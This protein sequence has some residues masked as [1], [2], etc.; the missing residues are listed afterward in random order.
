MNGISIQ[1]SPSVLT[2]SRAGSDHAQAM[3]STAQVAI[4]YETLALLI[5]TLGAGPAFSESGTSTA[6]MPVQLREPTVP[7]EEAAQRIA[8]NLSAAQTLVGDLLGNVNPEDLQL[9]QL[10]EAAT[11][12]TPPRA[13]ALS[14]T[15]ESERPTVQAIPETQR[16]TP[17]PGFPLLASS[18]LAQLLMYMSYLLM[19]FGKQE[20]ENS[21]EM[22]TFRRKTQ[23]EANEQKIAAAE[24]AIY[25]AATGLA[26]TTALGGVALKKTY[27]GTDMQ[28][29]NV[30]KNQ[31]PGNESSVAVATAAKATK[32]GS[33]PTIEQRP[34]RDI[35]GVA[36]PASANG[37]QVAA[38]LQADV[39]AG[40]PAMRAVVTANPARPVADSANAA[41]NVVS[42]LAQRPLMQGALA[43]MLAGVT[44]TLGSTAWQPQKSAQEAAEALLTTEAQVEAEAAANANEQKRNTMEMAQAFF[45]MAQALLSQKSNTADHIT[46]HI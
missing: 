8:L 42:A 1:L 21:A 3:K 20:R 26:L 18:E 33:L 30:I 19:E 11:T 12:A 4:G 6:A 5:S 39:D 43:N 40:T 24:T 7:A 32:T 14:R 2:T 38:D 41:S 17:S 37:G 44:G 9:P 13:D 15:S 45:Q 10:T 27:E 29:K 16:P 36:Q 22:T 28:T 34:A 46:R 25:A 31:V 23:I 35:H